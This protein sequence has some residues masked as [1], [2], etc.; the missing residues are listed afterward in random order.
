M[1]IELGPLPSASAIAWIDNAWRVLSMMSDRRDVPFG[2]PPA[3]RIAIESYFQ[4]WLATAALGPEFHWTGEED[5]DTVRLLVRYWYSIATLVHT[6]AEE[7][8]LPVAPAEA[9]PFYRAVVDAVL[10][11]LDDEGRKDLADLATELRLRWPK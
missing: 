8:G 10:E 1:K 5:P 11:A 7:L 3:A 4:E 2:V 6:R 9:E